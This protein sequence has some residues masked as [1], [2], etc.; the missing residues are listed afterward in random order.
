MV[1][2][3]KSLLA[4][5]HDFIDPYHCAPWTVKYDAVILTVLGVLSFF[6]YHLI[7][8]DELKTLF[9]FLQ[10]FNIGIHEVGHPVF[11]FITMGNEFWR[12]AGGGLT[13]LLVPGIA[14]LIFLRKGKP[15]QADFCIAWF[16]FSMYSVGNY[17]ASTSLPEIT[18]LNATAD[19]NMS[20][21]EYL[22][23]YFGT[24]YHD[25]LIGNIFYAVGAVIFVFAVYAFIQHL[26]KI[27]SGPLQKDISL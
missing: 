9:S 3:L 1:T 5:I 17:A 21:W 2:G 16:G 7:S 8:T 27:L 20:D 24:I 12:I 26:R 4:D 22:H 25:V 6:L 18:L 13:E 11:G 14:F 23:E 10:F 15:C 19:S